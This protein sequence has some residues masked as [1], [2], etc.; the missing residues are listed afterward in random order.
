MAGSEMDKIV[1][2]TSADVQEYTGISSSV[3][4]YQFSAPSEFET[5]LLASEI[6]RDGVK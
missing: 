4:L 2:G 3:N 6:I 5:S 1:T